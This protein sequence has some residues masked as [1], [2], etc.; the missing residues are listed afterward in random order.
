MML[1]LLQVPAD[2]FDLG[3]HYNASGK[4][5]NTS[6]TPFGCFI[7]RPGFFDTKLF[8][9]S[10]REA[11]QT[12][13]GQ[14]LILLTA[15]EAL[16]M[17]GYSPNGS[18]SFNK[19]RIG[20]F[21]GQ[22]TDDW[23][24][25]NASQNIDIYY[26]T[27][28]IRAFGPGR[29]NY[30]FKWDGPSYSF[31]TAC[32][33]SSV[34]IQMARSALL[35]R[36]C[37][38]AV[39]GGA[40]ILT[41]SDMFAGLSR[42]GFLSRTGSC[43]T[44]D[45]GADG[46]CR[47]DGA[48]S[49]VMKRLDDAIADGDNIQAILRSA[50]TNHSAQAVSIT[51]PHA[52]TQENLFHQVLRDADVGP[53]EIGYVEM[54]GTGTQAG[55]S[56][57]LAS[58]TNVL[59]K[60]RSPANPLHVGA[61]KANVGHSEGAAGITSVIK[62]IL[63][64]RHKV[65]PPHVG[66]KNHVNKNLQ[67]SLSK[68][69]HIP[70]AQIPFEGQ[71]ASAGACKVMVNNFSA[72]GGN[73]SLLLQGPPLRTLKGADPR[74]PFTVLV[75][76]R[77]KKSLVE[78]LRRLH[79]YLEAHPNTRIADLAYTTSARR[80]H[81]VYRH[82]FVAKDVPETK[83]GLAKAMED[84]DENAAPRTISSDNAMFIFSG[85]G[86][87]YPD[88]G[89]QLFK[90]C[91][92]FRKKALECERLALELG[93]TSFF[94]LIE[95]TSSSDDTIFSPMQ[96]QLALV[97]L[98]ISMASLWQSWGVYPTLVLGHSLGEYAAL[99]VSGVI[100]LSSTLYLV[101]KRAEL[102]QRS[103]TSNSHSML[104]A[105]ESLQK[106]RQLI[107]DSETSCEVSCV[108]GPRDIVLSGP[109]DQI[110]GLERFLRA[111]DIKTVLLK[112]P[113]AFHSSQMDPILDE[114]EVIAQGVKY[115]TP[116][117]R[118][119]STAKG[120]MIEHDK[121]LWP[122]YLRNQTRDPVLMFDALSVCK[123][124][125]VCDE[126][127]VWIECGPGPASLRM[128]KA[129]L[130]TPTANLLTS[131]DQRETDW[132]AISKSIGKAY[133]RGLDISWPDFHNGYRDCVRVLDLPPYSFDLENEWIK[134]EGD[135]SI[136]KEG[137]RPAP[138][139]LTTCVQRL[140]STKS[141]NSH[142]R[143][144]FES[145]FTDAGL[146]SLISGHHVHGF[147]LCPASV[148]TEMAFAAA[149]HMHS[150]GNDPEMKNVPAME[151]RDVEIFK[152]L[153]LDS[154]STTQKAQIIC[155]Q[156]DVTGI[157]KININSTDGSETT[158]HARSAVCFG[159]ANAWRDEWARNRHFIEDARTRLLRS[160]K[161]HKIL[162]S[163]VYRLF[164]S[165]V[166][167]DEQYQ[168]LE[169]VCMND[170]LHEATA[171]V[172]LRETSLDHGCVHNPYWI[173]CLAQLGGF[174]LNGSPGTSQDNVFL[175]HGWQALRLS[176]RLSSQKPYTCHVRMMPSKGK[177]VMVGDVYLLDQDSVVAACYGLEFR[178]MQKTVLYN[179]LSAAASHIHAP[180]AQNESR[181][182]DSISSSGN[183]VPTP[184]SSSTELS[185]TKIPRSGEKDSD[186][187]EKIALVIG[188]EIGIRCDEISDTST[189]ADMGL[190][191]L[192]TISI[193]ARVKQETG[194]TLPSSFFNSHPRMQDVRQYLEEPV[195]EG[196]ESSISSKPSQN[197][198]RSLQEDSHPRDPKYEG[199]RASASE[200]IQSISCPIVHLQGS[201]S[202]SP[203]LFLLPDGAGSAQSYM[204]LPEILSTLSVF[205]LDSAFYTRPQDFNISFEA[206]TSTFV[207]AIRSIQPH[208][209]YLLGGWSMGGM[210][211]YEAARQ[212]LSAGEAVQNLLM[213]DSPCPGTLPPLPAPTL[214]ILEKAGLFDGLQTMGRG[215]PEATRI[216]FLHSVAAL[217]NW[218][219]VPM[220]SA[221]GRPERVDVI[222]AKGGVL[223]EATEEQRK[224][225]EESWDRQ[226]ESVA[227]KA[228]DWLTG[229]RDSYGPAGWDQM[230]GESNV[231]C[232]NVEGN[233]FSIIRAP[234]VRFDAVF[235]QILLALLSPSGTEKHPAN[236]SLF[237]RSMLSP[238]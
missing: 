156:D 183:G 205:G 95:G 15:Y 219:P 191:S 58:V 3:S 138:R 211:A 223:D 10:P 94:R 236:I 12:D 87:Q 208:G 113:F 1:T 6:L 96:T 187:C 181:G 218:R 27:G 67:N 175:A 48:G 29:L 121:I 36:E 110:S 213:I 194:Q 197:E 13:P 152:P 105:Q 35:S 225:S 89:A 100:S 140:M 130:G 164:S 11:R 220:S 157:I 155:D 97:S 229:H 232:H 125:E 145:D 189:L 31:D 112:V 201:R 103:C 34:A 137:G 68:K 77:T 28:G 184:S 40:N 64:M 165:I 51:H 226:T 128:V 7:E 85:Q 92:V 144:V 117:I 30:H 75:S 186:L 5:K 118:F 26:V 195:Q 20:T 227:S 131:L 173:D 210:Y 76:A 101:G 33:S 170:D 122:T 151:L 153:V 90:Y 150:R 9:M 230:T 60:G 46:Y 69:L 79:T 238:L 123:E 115:S 215:V 199:T 160:N 4:T 32:S 81:H 133:E 71:G 127:S 65:I 142:S 136:T 167:Y 88:M 163:L 192:L 18:P 99:H 203:A 174:V 111:R 70:R 109:N 53:E 228:K 206:A 23:R 2:R 190:D 202:S 135:W 177:D 147:D 200:D 41:G 146:K 168:S 83:D 216:H 104:A 38:T 107:R 108:N 66:I 231:R 73:T 57:E 124:Q 39:A 188:E 207:R 222:W 78:N 61:I 50:A 14:R 224:I 55:D 171:I 204:Q 148:L 161:S 182:E 176:G 43:K 221:T 159:D 143:A 158:E 154:T 172:Q 21:F 93:F 62:A 16:E 63:M 56:T 54:H 169:E 19:H 134:Y 59:A 129:I 141:E 49:I 42:G 22:T 180:Q 102:M 74:T 44:F 235:C 212:L 132:A 120:C 8:N 80:M 106:M 193:L 178:K 214:S 234:Q 82:A 47:A 179:L 196:K 37:D 17:A 237:T 162:R 217:E 139:I 149:Y 166:D 114:F 91:Q 98:E 25:H 185:N 24:E 233:H 86:S 52:P 72:A 45:D 209:P 119:A 116:K 198:D 84:T 126:H